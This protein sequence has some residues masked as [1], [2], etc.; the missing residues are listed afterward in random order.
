MFINTQANSP[1]AVATPSP[2]DDKLLL[3]TFSGQEGLSQLFTFE[4]DVLAD[5]W[6]EVPFDVLLGQPIAVRLDVPG[7]PTR[8][9]HGLCSRVSQGGRDQHFTSY[10]LEMVPEFWLLTRKAQ[11][12]IFQQVSVPEIL[13]KVLEGLNVEYQ[14]QGT[15]HPRDFCV[16]YRE[17]DFAFASRLM[18]EEGIYYFF[19][20][21]ADGHQMVLANT[22]QSHPDVPG[23]TPIRY[24]AL[25]N[26]G[27]G[28]I[29]EWQKAQELR[30][31]KCTMWDHC[32]ELP[33]RHLQ[34]QR[35]IQES[36]QVGEISHKLKVGNNGHLEVYDWPG[37]YAQRFDGVDRAGGDRPAD[38]EKIYQDNERTVGIRMGQEAA[39][40]LAI[41]GAGSCRQLTAG[42]KFQLEEH[43]NADGAYILTRV[44]HTARNP[45]FRSGAEERFKYQN[46]FTCIPAELPFRPSRLTPRPV[47]AGTQSAVVVGMQGG[48]IFTDKYGRVKVKFHWD[49]Q[50]KYD[51]ESS[52]WIRVAQVWAGKGWGAHF[53]PRAGQEVVVAFEEGDP[54]RPII[55]G[56][57]YNTANMPP[58]ALPGNQTRSGIKTRSTPQGTAQQFNEL[59][60]EDRKGQEEIYV[61]AE[62]NLTTV[63]ESCECRAVGGRRSTTIHKGERLTVDEDGRETVITKGDEMLK[64]EDGKR[65]VH[66]MDNDELWVKAGDVIRQIDNGHYVLDVKTGNAFR[67]VEQGNDSVQVKTGSATRQVDTG[68]D[69][70]TVK[71]GH[72]YR[73]VPNGEYGI[74]AK[75]IRLEATEDIFLK[76]GGSTITI[77]TDYID[78]STQSLMLTGWESVTVKGE[79]IDLN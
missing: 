44:R 63:V 68:N 9:F 19:K 43:F 52:C 39:R 64:V 55:V 38:L 32:F 49:R 67:L 50:G 14:I 20:H 73:D 12:R 33:H 5:N 25:R 79:M 51:A 57:L 77:G 8:Y 71:T 27:E 69:A 34:A 6:T 17:T 2:L 75:V 66:V 54:D 74:K 60:F 10:R 70:I 42:H 56:S 35:D 29:Q 47:V 11:S 76:V 3:T 61:H 13:K 7:G 45:S 41:Q 58:Y 37:G 15:F 78:I 72:A 53:W 4:L 16:Q 22:P 48:E 62:R 65:E 31:S 18:E 28:H 26:G 36:V 1:M 23:A 40:S 30:S 59:R 24:S 21:D 46:T